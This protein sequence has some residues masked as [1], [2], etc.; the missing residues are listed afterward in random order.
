MAVGKRRTRRLDVNGVS[1]RWR[2]DFHEPADQFSSSYAA[3]GT[4]W[5]PDTL[6][7]RP[8]EGPHRLLTVTWPACHA[9]LVLPGLVRACIMEALHR[10]WLAEHPALTLAGNEASPATP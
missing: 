8:E 6:V 5:K 2:C 9:P 10:G 4:T 7:V 3:D 1:F